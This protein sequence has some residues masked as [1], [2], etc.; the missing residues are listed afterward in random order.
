MT[1]K[2]T[3]LSEIVYSKLHICTTLIIVANS[4][5]LPAQDVFCQDDPPANPFIAQSPW[6]IMH[7][8]SFAQQSTCLQAPQAGDSLSVRFCRAPLGRISTWLYYTEKYANGKRAILGSSATHLFKAVDDSLG[9]RVID[10]LRIDFNVLDYSWNH[11]LLRDRIWISYDYDDNGQ[12]NKVFKLTD[13]DTTDLYSPIIAID[14]ITLPAS[15]QG[16][17]SLLNVTQDGWIAFNTTG[18]T[19]GVIKPD[20]TQVITLNLPL[21]AG[22]IS[23]HNN[24]PVDADNSIFVVTTKK[25]IKLRWDNPNLSIEWTAPYDF[26]GNGPTATLAR[27]SGTT[28]TLVGWGNGNDKLV[29]VADGHSPNNMVVFWRNEVPANWT[30]LAGQDARVAGIVNLTGFQNL[31][32]GL[33][34]VENSVCVNGYDMAVAQFNGF[35]Y[36][37]INAKGVIKCRWDTLTNTLSKVWNNTNV[38]FNNAL[39]YSRQSNLVYGNGKETDC[40]NYFYGLD[41]NTGDVAIRK[42]LGPSDD[43]TDPGCNISINDDSTLV[44]PTGKGFIQIK[45]RPK[46]SNSHDIN[47]LNGSFSVFPNPAS[48]FSTVLLRVNDPNSSYILTLY[49]LTGQV[50]YSSRFSGGEVEIPSQREGLYFVRLVNIENQQA[51]G[52]P[53][54]K[55]L[56]TD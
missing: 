44:E 9:L 40:N 20:F 25:M 28:P 3:K 8:N 47:V 43:F 56:V 4:L 10:S 35:S 55:L 54:R 42:L 29:V 15:V 7:R 49:N 36:D 48:S 21:T 11:L 53:V 33:Q 52:I 26:V 37:C 27:G 45:Y 5:S 24:F 30:P 18:G 34:S 1:G 51:I 19:F 46:P 39:T 50:M 13:Q 17:V 23:Y 6:P 38:N 2:F 31:D 22:E 41:W 14:T 12:V 32:N 16:K